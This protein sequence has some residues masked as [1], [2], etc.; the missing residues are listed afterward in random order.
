MKKLTSKQKKLLSR[1][2]KESG[3]REIFEGQK[4]CKFDIDD[5]TDEQWDILIDINDTD[6]L[7]CYVDIFLNDLLRKEI[8]KNKE[9]IGG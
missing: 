4:H 5:L 1:W 9:L 2:F 3:N 7:S 8:I 6:L